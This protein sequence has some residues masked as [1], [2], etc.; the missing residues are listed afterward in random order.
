MTIGTLNAQPTH[1]GILIAGLIAAGIMAASFASGRSALEA[2]QRANAVAIDNE[3]QTL[4]DGLG[5]RLETETYRKCVA[6]LS[7]IRLRHEQRLLVEASG[8][9]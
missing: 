6:G 1:A 5:F 9:L 8:L 7:E 2:T 4:C 3:N